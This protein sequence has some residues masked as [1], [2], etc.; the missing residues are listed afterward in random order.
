MLKEKEKGKDQHESALKKDG[1]PAYTADIGWLRYPYQKTK[2]LSKK[3]AKLEFKVFKTSVDPT[4]EKT[5]SRCRII[6]KTLGKKKDLILDANQIWDATEATNNIEALKE[7][8]LLC[9]ED[10][11]SPYDCYGYSSISAENKHIK[12]A[13]GKM[14]ANRIIHKEFKL[15]IGTDIGQINVARLGGI[16]EALA[17]YFIIRKTKQGKCKNNIKSK[18]LI[19]GS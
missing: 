12:L 2:D 7:F 13:T 11:T 10:P 3:F 14:C 15:F 18:C 9:I 4:L 5:I 19:F 16:N 17:V 8:N 6:R 1:Y